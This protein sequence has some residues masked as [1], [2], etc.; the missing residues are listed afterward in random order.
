MI[1]A[2]AVHASANP[3][4]N[5]FDGPAAFHDGPARGNRYWDGAIGG[6]NNPV[7]AAVTEAIQ[8]GSAPSDIAALSIGT[9]TVALPWP[10]PNEAPS[11]LTCG[12]TD[13]N[14]ANDL[15][16]L[17]A[18]IVDDPP[19]FAT[20]VAHVV[21]G[22]ANGLMA[23]MTS[24][25]VRLNPLISPVRA[26]AGGPWSAPPGMTTAGFLSLADL[27]FDAVEQ[28]QVNAIAAY[29]TLWLQDK[30]P[31]QPIRMNG[32]TLD[33]EIGDPWFS[34]AAARWRALKAKF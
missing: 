14:L 28:A 19:D 10:Q 26:A 20:F 15:R 27:D 2:E 32:D 6:F 1:L 16:K 11:P 29:A 17:A 18:A 5:Y 4:I 7:L 3:P 12:P 22:G 31:N 34:G 8:L 21:T 33:C 24:R 25:V 23:P 13:Q 9:G 30:A